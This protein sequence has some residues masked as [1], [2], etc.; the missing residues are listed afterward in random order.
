M[1][2]GLVVEV[3]TLKPQVLLN[4]THGKRFDLAPRLV[5]SLPNDLAVD[6]SHLK[7]RADLVGMEVVKLLLCLTFYYHI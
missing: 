4:L 5:C 7:R 3:L 2:P 1:Q 6:I